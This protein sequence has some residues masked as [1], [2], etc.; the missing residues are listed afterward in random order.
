MNE[1]FI[2]LQEKFFDNDLT[3]DEK[4]EFEKLLN[5]N[6][7]F[8]IEFNEQQRIKEVFKQMQL[9]NPSKE[10]WDGYW[11][12]IYRKIERGLGWI[13]FSIGAIILLG[14]AL[15][16]LTIS[17]WN[18]ISLPIYIKFSMLSLIFGLIILA[19]SIFREKIF[20]FKKDKYKEIQR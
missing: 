18:D 17:I 8:K 10:V 6:P 3:I 11:L 14:F 2:Y 5:E 19:V 7:I 13:F 12:G 15:Y 16:Q 9:K 1:R 4:S 20:L